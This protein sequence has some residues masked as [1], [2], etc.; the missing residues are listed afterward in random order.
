MDDYVTLIRLLM[1]MAI[2]LGSTHCIQQQILSTA[3]ELQVI[4]TRLK[5]KLPRSEDDKGENTVWGFYL[6]V[7]TGLY[8]V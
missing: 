8:K 3:D 5:V 4:A 6:H 2:S 7:N 1:V